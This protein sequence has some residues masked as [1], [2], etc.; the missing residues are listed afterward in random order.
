M[1][2][3]ASGLDVCAR[4]S[5]ALFS[6]QRYKVWRGR[7]WFREV[8]VA[9]VGRRASHALVPLSFIH[10][11]KGVLGQWV[12]SVPQLCH[13]GIQ[14]LFFLLLVRLLFQVLC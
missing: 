2:P 14:Q 12:F 1:K 3:R 9:A 5:A 6:L 10:P 11:F 13:H 4:A 8:A 7:R